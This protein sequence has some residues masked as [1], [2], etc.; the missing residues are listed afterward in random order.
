MAESLAGCLEEDDSLLDGLYTNGNNGKQ[1]LDLGGAL[2]PLQSSNMSHMTRSDSRSMRRK[3]LIRPS[4][5]TED[6]LNLLHGSDPVKVELNRLENEVR[7]KT[8]FHPQ[9]LFA[10]PSQKVQF[11]TSARPFV[12]VSR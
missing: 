7:G 2:L 1:S 3:S 4:L 11:T 12:V 9:H 8:P 5:E 6:L 10:M